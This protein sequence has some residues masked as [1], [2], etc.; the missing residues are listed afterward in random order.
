MPALDDRYVR[1]LQDFNAALGGIVELLQQDINERKNVDSVNKMPSN[2]NDD[3]KSIVKNMEVVLKTTKEIK[4]QNDKILHE[5]L[6][7]R[8]AKETGMFGNIAEVDNKRKI[9]DAVKV[10]TL[11]AAGVLAIGLAFKIIAPVNF[12][13]IIAIGLAIVFIAGAFITVAAVTE[14]LEI[15]D[16]VRISGMMVVMALGLAVSSWALAITATLTFAKAISIIFV[17]TVMGVSLYTI[18]RAVHKSEIKLSD[19]PKILLLPIA[20]PLIALGLAISSIFLSRIVPL[21]FAQMATTV[22]VAA[23]IGLSMYF[24]VQALDKSKM[25]RKHVA[26][27]LLLPIMVPALALGL[28]IAS[29]ILKG[30]QPLSFMQMISAIFVAVTIGVL[31]YL[32]HPMIE[33]MKSFTLGQV[34]LAGALVAALATGLV[35]ASWIL[36]NM[37]FFTIR[38]SIDLIVTSLAIGLA[39][40]FLTPAVY[41]LKKIHKDEMQKAARNIIIAA[42]AIM[43]SSLILNLGT[44]ENYPDWQWSFGAG[45]S[46]IAFGGI[47]WALNKMGLTKDYKSIL[48]GGLAIIAISAVIMISSLILSI[49]KYDEYPSFGWAIGVGLSLVAFGGAMMILG[50]IIQATGGI[51]AA[52]LAIGAL[53]TIG[54]AATIM[55]TSL[56]L[57]LGKYDEYPSIGWAFGVGLSLIAFGGAMMV[58]GGLILATGGIAAGAMAIGAL[59]TLLVTGAIVAVSYILGLGDYGNYPDSEWAKGVGLSMILFGGAMMILGVI[60]PLGFIVLGIGALAT[61]RVARTVVAVASIL[62][63][64]D[65]TGGPTMEWALGTGALLMAV[66]LTSVLFAAL[67][68]L[69]LL[70][71]FG[72]RRVAQSIVDVAKIL[73]EGDY[74]RGPTKKWAE[75]VGGAIMAFAKGIATLREAGGLFGRLF[76]GGDQSQKI[77]QIAEAMKIANIILGSVPW[78]D[79]YPSKEWSKG[80]GGAIMAFADGIKKLADADIDTGF[81]FIM[82]VTMISWGIIK[83]AQILDRFDWDKIKNYPKAEWS[84]GVGAAINAFAKPLAEMAKYDVTGRDI[85][86]GIRRLSRGLIDAAEIIGYYDWSKAVSYPH[87]DW[88]RGVGKAVGTFVD[89]LVKIEKNDVGIGDLRILNITIKAMI[90]TAK[91]LSGED[92]NIWNNYPTLKWAEGVGKAVGVFVQYLT[93]IEK[94]DIGRGEVKILNKIIDQMTQAA[95]KFAKVDQTIWTKYPPIEWS[96]GIEATVNAFAKSIKVLSNLDENNFN[97]LN[98][99]GHAILHFA[100]HISILE[101]HR[102]LFIKGGIFDNFSQSL[103]K[104]TESLPTKEKIQG[105]LAL[106]DA[107]SRISSRGLSMGF[108]IWMLSRAMEDLGK[109]LADLDLSAMD[110]LSKFSNG[111]LVLSLIDDKKLE[112]ALKI[113]DKKK[114]DIKAILSDNTVVRA[115]EKLEGEKVSVTTEAAPVTEGREEFYDQLLSFVKN[116]DTNVT[117]IATKEPQESPT[118]EDKEGAN[119]APPVK[120]NSS[121]TNKTYK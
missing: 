94:A 41:I 23:A 95:E 117:L 63:S 25:E 58:L 57:G 35:A 77:I 114:E 104:L 44:Y 43:I 38:Q 84:K 7:A 2:M 36:V 115:K 72:M 6:E 51:A 93:K 90:K 108:S 69:L 15:R 112:N 50:L 1:K 24:I 11:I 91:D 81:N 71:G 116:I 28:V 78:S 48:F 80:V 4:S 120:V 3:L 97:L 16:V 73:A 64:G 46:I 49:G 66:G 27:L 110:K 33:K 5:V 102:E 87:E 65:Y 37:K 121:Q 8:K 101:K 92:A 45:L 52:A 55:A 21:T 83:A 56:I 68:P 13:S 30:I 105:L 111:M 98:K 34:L 75:G 54:V 96:K 86:K 31:V 107:L 39:V 53:A 82:M 60:G 42:G 59:A 118:G 18:I 79:N 47:V 62:S 32:M 40:L 29:V 70:G 20:L 85:S 100:W 76:G 17:A 61:M 99:A 14:G 88:V 12:L 74:T 109:T 113:I 19:Y 22:F 26:Q 103:K 119:V 89:F 106:G 9:I 67:L 10:I